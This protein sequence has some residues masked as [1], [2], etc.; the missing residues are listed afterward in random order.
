MIFVLI[1]MMSCFQTKREDIY[2]IKIGMTYEQVENIMPHMNISQ[3]NAPN[4]Y[5]YAYNYYS[6]S[7]KKRT[8][9]VIIRN[10]KV[11]NF[12]SI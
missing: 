2:K 5:Y 10:G 1:T 3:Y 11:V 12:Y 8:F 7:G 9:W 6:E 4:D